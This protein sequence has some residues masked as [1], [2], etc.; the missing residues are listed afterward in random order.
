MLREGKA[1]ESARDGFTCLY[2]VDDECGKTL[3]ASSDDDVLDLAW[4]LNAVLPYLKRP[5][6][7]IHIGPNVRGLNMAE[8]GDIAFESFFLSDDNPYLTSDGVCLYSPD[9][10]ELVACLV[11]VESYVVPNGVKDI[12]AHAFE[13][14]GELRSVTLPSSLET[15]GAHAFDSCVELG[16]AVLSEGIATVGERAFFGTS[17]RAVQ[18][19]ASLRYAG[20]GAFS[21][22]WRL[23]QYGDDATAALP[24]YIDEGNDR[25][26]VQDDF[27]C[28]RSEDGVRALF[29]LSNAEEIEVPNGVTHI[30][31]Y[32]L[33]GILRAR[34][35][36]L[37]ETLETVGEGAFM[38]GDALEHLLMYLPDGRTLELYPAISP[39]HYTYLGTDGYGDYNMGQLAR[40]CDLS[41]V[42]AEPLAVRVRRMIVRLRNGLLMED[43]VRQV[44]V[45]ALSNDL[46]GALAVFA[47]DDDV[48]SLQALCDFGLVALHNVDWAIGVTNDVGGVRATSLLLDYSRAIRGGR[49]SDLDL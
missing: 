37:P 5:A 42:R 41:M 1:M 12:G 24:V 3:V 17:L 34:S 30:G 10:L 44:I 49:M 39:G 22:A 32:A 15:I 2:V 19:P 40:E 28:E 35:V 7:S 23:W 4:V 21:S 33:L 14:L 25:F 29:Y 8:R 36:A 46:R 9:G 27:L 31:D 11:N 47:H 20:D 6:M 45:D 48:D 26:F 38:I 43:D 18:I 16:D 13:G